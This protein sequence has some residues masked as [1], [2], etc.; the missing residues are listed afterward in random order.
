MKIKHFE[1]VELANNFLEENFD[2]KLEIPIEFNTRIK[3][4]FG[5]FTY[6]PRTRKALKIQMSVD[7]MLSHPHEHIIDVLK[8]ELVHYALFSKGLPH[9][10]GDYTF[11]STLKRL[12]INR[13]HTYQYLG[14]VHQYTCI[15]C[16]SVF[17]RKR[18]IAK[19]ARCGCSHGE[20]LRYDGVFQ[21]EYDN[22]VAF[23]GGDN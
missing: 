12:G 14:E 13:T 6:E 21:K 18:K 19:T 9:K 15:N 10:D 16:G 22:M 1:M 11:E 17:Q 4:V 20:N 2:M 3:R 5:R 23:Q 8:H 7:F